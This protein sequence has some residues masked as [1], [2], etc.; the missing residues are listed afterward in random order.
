MRAEECIIA[1]PSTLENFG[2]PIEMKDFDCHVIGRL[3]ETSFARARAKPVIWS[4]TQIFT[5][6]HNLGLVVSYTPFYRT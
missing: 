6:K 1:K 5:Q 3:Y 4:H 2:E